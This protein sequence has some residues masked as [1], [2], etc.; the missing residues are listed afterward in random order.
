MTGYQ[1][2]LAA[3]QQFKDVRPE[4]CAKMVAYYDGWIEQIREGSHSVTNPGELQG[5]WAGHYFECT[6]GVNAPATDAAGRFTVYFGFD[7]R[8]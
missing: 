6:G 1:Q 4:S 3:V 7:R 5:K 2:T 8:I